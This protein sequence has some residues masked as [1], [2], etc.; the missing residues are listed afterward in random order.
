MDDLFEIARPV[1]FVRKIIG[2]SSP[3]RDLSISL[4]LVESSS[5]TYSCVSRH[6]D[7]IPLIPKSPLSRL[8]RACAP[9]RIPHSSFRAL[10]S[11]FMYLKDDTTGFHFFLLLECIFI[12]IY[13]FFLAPSPILFPSYFFLSPSGAEIAI[14][15]PEESPP[16]SLSLCGAYLQSLRPFL[17][18][19][20]RKTGN[21]VRHLFLR[22]KDL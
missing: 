9:T 11:R 7:V 16:L 15:N 14:V 3:P 19:C 21:N 6:F 12:Y 10:T 5:S 2:D 4:S 13:F 17:R 18:S 8:W 1:S 20:N 22:I